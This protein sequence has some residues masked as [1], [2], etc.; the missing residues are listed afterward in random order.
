[1]KDYKQI[2]ESCARHALRRAFMCEKI[3]PNAIVAEIGVLYGQFS[4]QI[5]KIAKPKRLYL[6]DPWDRDDA[7]GERTPEDM[8]AMFEEVFYKYCMLENVRVMRMLSE[9]FFNWH[10]QKTNDPRSFIEPL[11]FVYID[12][13]HNQIYQDLCGA[14]EAVRPGGLITGDDWNCRHWGNGVE[15]AVK[16]FCAEKGVTYELFPVGNLPAQFLIRR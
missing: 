15:L 1:M 5:L 7:N 4:E 6:V 11:D 12:G 8:E 14:W 10:W 16:K 9:T 2:K 3:P 13:D